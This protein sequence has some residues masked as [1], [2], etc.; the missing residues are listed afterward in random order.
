MVTGALASSLTLSSL[1]PLTG[2]HDNRISKILASGNHPQ[3]LETVMRGISRSQRVE[4]TGV[5]SNSASLNTVSRLED[6]F[7]RS[8]FCNPYL[9]ADIFRIIDYRTF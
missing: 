8:T 3:R 5:S 6:P 2:Q 4:S 1:S 9:R 7:E